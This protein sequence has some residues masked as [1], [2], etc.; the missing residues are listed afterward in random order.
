MACATEA[1]CAAVQVCVRL[2]KGLKTAAMLLLSWL[3]SCVTVKADICV[4]QSEQIAQGV[5]MQP[6]YL[7][8]MSAPVRASQMQF[9]PVVRVMSHIRSGLKQS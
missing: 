2:Q 4:R 8:H 9:A 3:Y 1:H 7:V 5:R 6:L